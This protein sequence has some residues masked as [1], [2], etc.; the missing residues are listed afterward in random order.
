MEGSLGLIL[1]ET[2]LDVAIEV[3]VVAFVRQKLWTEAFGP[4]EWEGSFGVGSNGGGGMAVAA[5]GAGLLFLNGGEGGTRTVGASFFEWVGAIGV[6][7]GFPDGDW[8][9]GKR[10]LFAWGGCS[11][12]AAVAEERDFREDL[13]FFFLLVLDTTTQRSSLLSVFSRDKRHL[14]VAVERAE[15]EKWLSTSNILLGGERGGG[16]FKILE[17]SERSSRGE[18]QRSVTAGA[19]YCLRL[20]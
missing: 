1:G 15:A 14:A 4:R 8:V 3:D 6:G 7:D 9:D 17:L 19:C 20:R 13:F 2:G 18:K 10:R 5:L 16:G 12:S 11:V